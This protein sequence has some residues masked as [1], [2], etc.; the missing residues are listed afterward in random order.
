MTKAVLIFPPFTQ[1]CQ[2]KKRC[3]VPLGIAYIG[4]YLRKH[5][6]DVTLIDS[7]V[8]GYDNEVY[9]ND[10]VTIGLSMLDI[11]ERIRDI[12][13]DFV[14]V[15]SLMTAQFP[16][17]LTVCKTVKD[18]NPD[19]HVVI[20]GCHPSVF[21]QDMLKFPEIDSVVIGEGEQSMLD[22]VKG[23]VNGVV[24]RK[25]LDINTIPHPARDLLPMEKYIAINMPENMFSPF[26][27]VTQVVSS[28]GCPFNCVFCSTT[29]LHGHWRGRK[30]EDVIAE[31]QMLKNTYGIEEINF[32]DENLVM[33]RERIVKILEGFKKIGIAWSNPGGIW[34]DGLDN[35][36]LDLM[37]ASG[38]YQLTF[39]VETSN[40]KILKKVI[41]KPIHIEKV[42]PLV[43]H[44][45]KIGIDVHA[46]FVCG[47]P[48][49]TKQDMINDFE[50]AKRV[51]FDSASF[52]I[53]TPL[54]GSKIYDQYHDIDLKNINYIHSTI[55]HPTL[56]SKEI[57]DLVNSFNVEFNKLLQQR[58]PVKF[59]NKYVKT[60]E[61]KFHNKDYESLLKRV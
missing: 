39:P 37:K 25:P 50:Y 1:P 6:I 5:G 31:A 54:P 38:C 8:E 49:Q 30:A 29:N 60:A 23:K 44:C 59:Y 22:I 34:I 36:L 4:G 46:F 41:N 28:R 58:D 18:V 12:E 48:Q 40:E 61:K 14:G 24:N 13:P 45:H 26:D 42:E 57:E 17:A 10:T 47:F 35:D 53:I 19:I 3:L 9:Q 51:A 55:P 16:N 7:Y 52:H 27:R 43:K 56:S 33:N 32:I 2:S 11:K 20:G 15:S 21:P